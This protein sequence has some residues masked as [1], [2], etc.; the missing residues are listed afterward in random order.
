MIIALSRL[1]YLCIEKPFQDMRGGYLKPN[2][3]GG[4]AN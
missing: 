2:S 3:P 4:A 1:S